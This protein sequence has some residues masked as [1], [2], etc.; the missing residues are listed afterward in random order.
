MGMEL[1]VL[2]QPAAASAGGQMMDIAQI[3]IW[4]SQQPLGAIPHFYQAILATFPFI[5]HGLDLA[6]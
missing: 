6:S 2:R 4:E 3:W 5:L 1:L